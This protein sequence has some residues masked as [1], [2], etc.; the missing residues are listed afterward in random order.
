L[1]GFPVGSLL[2]SEIGDRDSST[3]SPNQYWL[4]DGQQ[5][6]TTIAMGFYDPWNTH[7]DLVDADKKQLWS[8]RVMPVLWIDFGALKTEDDEKLF[9]PYLVTQSHPWGYNQ[10]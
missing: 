9:S 6:A 4:L 10:F 3:N 5:R 1:R 2:L 7:A 8:L